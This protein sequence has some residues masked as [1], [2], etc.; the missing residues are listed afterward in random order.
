MWAYFRLGKLAGS[1]LLAGVAVV[2]CVGSPAPVLAHGNDSFQG[3]GVLGDQIRYGKFA[4]C[5]T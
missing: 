2:A 4:R 5:K 3:V 1:C